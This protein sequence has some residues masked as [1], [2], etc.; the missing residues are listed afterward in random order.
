MRR[1]LKEIRDCSE[2]VPDNNCSVASPS[3][4]PEYKYPVKNPVFAKKPGLDVAKPGHN[5]DGV[6][7][8]PNFAGIDLKERFD[9]IRRNIRLEHVDG[10]NR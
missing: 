10:L 9:R 8:P 6:P 3:K 1:V 5:G 2:P 7:F 4:S